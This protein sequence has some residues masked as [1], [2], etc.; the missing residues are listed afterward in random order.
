M[1]SET[2]EFEGGIALLD[3]LEVV[4]RRWLLHAVGAAIGAALAVLWLSTK[5]PSYRAQATLLLEQEGASAGVLGDLAALTQAPVAISEMEILRSRSVAEEVV[6]APDRA[7]NDA[8]AS[9]ADALGLTTIV[10]DP[11]LRPLLRLKER[12]EGG[13]R[14]VRGA[15]TLHATGALPEGDPGPLELEVRF[16]AH[17]QVEIAALG[18]LGAGEPVQRPF[19]PDAP[20]EAHGATLRL[21]PA[22]DPVD[23]TWRVTLL[24]E[25]DALERVG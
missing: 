15:D 21:R 14:G 16:I 23:R 6:A 11:R 7:A 12:L 10:D 17:D 20:I 1:R 19:A 13:R 5:D 24:S 18:A 25:A 2:Q 3:L 22:V 9:N 4:R 8:Q